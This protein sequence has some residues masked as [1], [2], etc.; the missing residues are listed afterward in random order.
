MVNGEI[1][2][3]EAKMETLN[4]N[5]EEIHVKPNTDQIGFKNSLEHRIT[6]REEY[7]GGWYFGGAE[8]VT[9]YVPKV[10]RCVDIESVLIKCSIYIAI[11]GTYAFKVDDGV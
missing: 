6:Y 1:R 8:I 10:M 7:G 4:V 3:Y 11:S 5:E 2:N 9:P